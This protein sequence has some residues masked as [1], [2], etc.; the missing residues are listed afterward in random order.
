ME[1]ER[2]EPRFIPTIVIAECRVAA[3]QGLGIDDVVALLKTKYPRLPVFRSHV[4]EL[5]WAEYGE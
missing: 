3:T 1:A 5:L 2:K 4:K